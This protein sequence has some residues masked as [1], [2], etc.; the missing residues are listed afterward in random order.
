[1]DTQRGLGQHGFTMPSPKPRSRK[2]FRL[3]VASAKTVPILEDSPALP[4]PAAAIGGGAGAALAGALLVCGVALIGWSG[5][6]EVQITAVLALA[7]Q[8]WLLSNGG[9]LAIDGLQ[10]TLVPLGFTLLWVALTAS[11]G[12]FAFRQLKLAR[13]G[14]AEGTDRARLVVLTALLVAVGYTAAALAVALAVGAEAFRV[15]PGA[16][17]VGI[18]GSI[19]GAGWRA[20]YRLGGPSWLRASLRGASAGVLAL[21]LAS[22]VVLAVALVQGETRIATLEQALGLDVGGNVVWAIIGLSYLPDLLGWSVAWL[23]GAGFTIGDGS[24][25]APWATRLGLLPSIP[26]LGALPS[27][28]TGGLQA[29]MAAGVLAGI[30][31]GVVSIRTEGAEPTRAIG[32]GTLAGLFTGLASVAWTMSSRGALGTVRFAIVGPQWPQVLIGVGIL[33]LSAALGAS[34]AWFISRKAGAAD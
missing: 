17:A 14:L 20:G 2:R 32:A 8:I 30:V 22:A 24:L 18:G 5:A 3:N 25:V 19:V 9:V 23:L 21:A 16:F 34:A 15:V 11:I 7:G 13:A 29:W 26:M 27:D 33:T 6:S 4:W 10:L 1:M 12:S 28:G 31:A